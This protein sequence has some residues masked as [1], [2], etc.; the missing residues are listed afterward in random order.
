[1]KTF[2]VSK[3]FNA[4]HILVKEKKIA[5]EIIKKLNNKSSFSELAKQFST[6]PSGKNGGN[7]NWFGLGQMVKPFEEAIIKLKK[8]EITQKSVQTKFG[9]HVIQ[10]ITKKSLLDLEKKI[11]KNQ[12]IIINKFEDV[13][14]KFN[15]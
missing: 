9:F 1:M 12:K 10:V 15:N 3:E 11:K 8:G 13:A 14:K 4:S 5:S 2:K 6:G 7:L